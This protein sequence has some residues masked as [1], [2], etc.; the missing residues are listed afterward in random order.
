MQI[1]LRMRPPAIITPR[2]VSRVARRRDRMDR[3]V[4]R[5]CLAGLSRSSP[6]LI[7]ACREVYTAGAPA[8]ALF[9]ENRSDG[10]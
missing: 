8:R 10:S 1:Q 6:S 3:S 5:E 9:R 7:C 4:L 2:S